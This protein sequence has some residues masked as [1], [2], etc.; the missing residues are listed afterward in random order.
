[1]SASPTRRLAAVAVVGHAPI[2]VNPRG[3]QREVAA[4][5][6][7]ISPTKFDQLVT[8]GRMPQ[9]RRL[10]GRKLW[11]RLELDEAFSDLPT[12]Q[13]ENPWDALTS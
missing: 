12:D 13:D 9:P 3:L 7:G 5:Y 11:D 6:I 2:T 1:M 10:D 4:R 8:D